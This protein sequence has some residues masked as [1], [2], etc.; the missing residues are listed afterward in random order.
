MKGRVKMGEDIIFQLI[1]EVGIE[2]IE[3]I[4]DMSELELEKLAKKIL[5]EERDI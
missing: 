1:Y 5:D 4:K 2:S 3:K